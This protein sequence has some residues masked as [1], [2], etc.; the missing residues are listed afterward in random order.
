MALRYQKE[1]PLRTW[2][3]HIGLKDGGMS[4]ICARELSLCG[5]H[6]QIVVLDTRQTCAPAMRGD[7]KMSYMAIIQ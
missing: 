6:A 7:A 4:E 2:K 1:P 3:A 5:G